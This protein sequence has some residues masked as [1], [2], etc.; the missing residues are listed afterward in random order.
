MNWGKGIIIAMTLFMGFIVYL[1][2][3]LMSH[4]VDLESEDYYLREIA[5]EDEISALNAATKNEAIK[6]STTETHVVIQI[7][8][9]G[10]YDDVQVDF[11]RPNDE[12]LDRSYPIKGSKTLTIEKSEL[13]LG[14]YN[15]EISY[16]DGNNN[17]LQKEKVYI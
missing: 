6:V 14:Q 13:S 16:R 5:Y 10:T 4:K 7:P 11:S 8:T 17:C 12:N 2:V 9:T 1:V 15:I 3:V